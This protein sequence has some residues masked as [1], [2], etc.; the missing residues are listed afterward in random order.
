MSFGILIFFKI[1]I[2]FMFLFLCIFD[3][4]VKNIL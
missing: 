4:V 3:N 2:Y 1:Y